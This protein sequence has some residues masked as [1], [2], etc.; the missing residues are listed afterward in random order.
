MTKNKGYQEHSLTHFLARLSPA[1]QLQVI[2]THPFFT[3]QCPK[4]RQDFRCP[5]FP[6]SSWDCAHCG[7]VDIS[8]HQTGMIPDA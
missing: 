5:S 6:P 3:G 1:E 7:W 8:G 4:C 2:M